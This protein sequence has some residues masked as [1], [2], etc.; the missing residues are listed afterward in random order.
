MKKF[1]KIS[2]CPHILG[3][4]EPRTLKFSGETYSRPGY[5]LLGEGR[6]T[7]AHPYW[8]DASGTY[9]VMTGA[10]SMVRSVAAAGWG[11]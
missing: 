11:L 2:T 8:I 3:I 7:L 5:F 4:E 1:A 9:L 6:Y 10:G